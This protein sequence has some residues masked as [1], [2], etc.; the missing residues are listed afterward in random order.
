MTAVPAHERLLDLVIALT[1]A[2]PMMTKEQIRRRVRGYEGSGEGGGRA[3]EAFERKFDRDK[4]TLRRLGVPLLTLTSV[5]HEDEVG[6]RIDMDDYEL[7]RV[8]LTTAELGVLS[9]AAE[10]WQDSQVARSARRALTKLRA[11][12]PQEAGET[13]PDP[14]P[15]LAGAA[16]LSAPQES[17]ADLLGAITDRVAVTFSYHA[18]RTGRT[19]GRRVEPWRIVARERGWYL[20]GWDR[21]RG[22]RRTFRLS[23]IEGAVTRL[24]DG[25]PIEIPPAHVDPAESGGSPGS[26]GPTR[27]ARST[28]VT[29]EL[30][31][32]TDRAG[33]LRAAGR[34]TGRLGGRAS[35]PERDG[36]GEERDVLEIEV[37]DPETFA[38]ELAGYGDAVVV[39]AP[40]DLR[41]AVLARLRAVAGLAEQAGEAPAEGSAS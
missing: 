22:D 7:P 40:A 16:V 39:L 33:R 11:R 30:A 9:L 2:R 24:A 28:L 4:E 21:D 31:V 17:L 19:S 34:V 27:S 3:Q 29:A 36:A 8:R 10:A 41:A 6:Y 1:Q 25:A 38:G 12:S 35:D 15:W 32:R 20:V 37:A 14:S 13:G 23:R 18:A 26:T 5:V